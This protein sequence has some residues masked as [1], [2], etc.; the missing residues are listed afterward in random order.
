MEKD[1]SKLTIQQRGGVARAASLSTQ[2]RKL[3]ASQMAKARWGTDL[4]RASHAGE[5]IIGDKRIAC[6][7]LENSKRLL[8]QETFLMALGRA[9]KAKGGTGSFAVDGMPPFLAADNLMPFISDDLRESTTP[10]FFK[11]VSGG[12]AAGYDALLLPKVCDVYLKMRDDYHAQKKEVPKNQQHIVT[13][14]D[15]LIRGLAHVG[16][17]ALVDEATGYQADKAKRELSQILEAYIVA[18]LRP[19]L[20]MFPAEFF[21]QIYRL[22]GWDYRP[23][24][25]H[26]PQ[27]VAKF[28][29]RY[30]Y[31]KLPEKVLPK[32]RELNP[33]TD[34]GYRKHK[35]FQFL[36]ED[37]G[38]PHLDKQI[39][40][41]TTLMRISRDKTEFNDM[42][43]RA[44]EPHYQQQMPLIVDIP[45][46]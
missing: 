25:T 34:K 26:R 12:R 31:E 36:T 30:I 14:C 6:A 5:I 28:I 13:A 42:F 1:T 45:S 10:V 16:I 38:S 43:G 18:E 33:L 9:G 29:N 21:K 20:T 23:G 8:T 2:E 15:L 40:T 17:I 7:V 22:H 37:T 4:P 39:S 27:Y 46:D 3:N 24:S 44:F 41:V 32:L 35:H 11:A 19:Y